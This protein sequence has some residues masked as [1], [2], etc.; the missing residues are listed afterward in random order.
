MGDFIP[1]HKIPDPHNVR[2]EL[3]VNGQVVQNDNTNLMLFK[4]PEL[5]QAVSSVMTLRNGDIL[6][7]TGSVRKF[8]D[9]F[10]WN[11]KGSWTDL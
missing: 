3:Q 10:S 7:S 4:I 6:L 8:A 5:L 2:L 11:A 9:A 1:K